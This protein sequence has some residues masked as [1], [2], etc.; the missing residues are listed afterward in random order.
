MRGGLGREGGKEGGK[1]G[2]EGGR[3]ER[4]ELSQLFLLQVT[5]G[6]TRLATKILGPCTLVQAAIPHIL[7]KVPTDYHQQNLR[8]FQANA[9]HIVTILR[10]AL[11]LKPIMPQATMYCMVSRC[12]QPVLW[13]KTYDCSL[14]WVRGELIN[15]YTVTISKGWSLPDCPLLTAVCCVCGTGGYR[16]GTLP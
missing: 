10:G 7:S 5:P 13:G 15:K 1:E 4:G 9:S 2:R 6:L 14:W 11:G 8:L 12:I 16:T 3:E